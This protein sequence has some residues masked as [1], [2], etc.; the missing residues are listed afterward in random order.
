MNS[1]ENK[2]F[3]REL[4]GVLTGFRQVTDLLD[5]REKWSLAIATVLMLIAGFL[6]NLPAV[7]LGRFV[8]EII[9]LEDATFGLA[10]P[11]L[12]WIVL[13]ILLKEI[14][15]ILRKYLIEN[16]ATQSDKKQTVFVIDHLL[17]TDIAKFVNRYRVGALHGRIFRSIQ[18]FIRLLKL[19]FLDFFPTFFTAIAALF[20]AFYQKPILASFMILVIP[21]GLF[22]VI[23]QISSQKGIRL[24]LLRGKEEIDGKVVEMMGGLET[25]RVANTSDYEV[26][27]IETIAEKLRKI[28]I[29]HHVSMAFYDAAKYLNE[30]FFYLLVVSMSIF[31]AVNGVITKGDILT[32]S[33]LFMSVLSPLR[34]VH[35]ILDQA[36]ESSLKVA[37]LVDLRNQPLDQSF[38]VKSNL[39]AEE[40]EAVLNVQ[41]MSFS[42]SDDDPILNRISLK[43]HKGEKIGIAGASGSGKS[44]LIK[45]LL[46]LVHDYQGE[47]SL[48]GKDLKCLTRDEI[49]DKIA[50]IPQRTYIFSG[51]VR[52]NILYGCSRNVSDQ[53]V[54][55]AAREANID[56]E[57]SDKL[58]GLCGNVAENGSNLSGGQ[59]QRLALARLILRSPDILIFDEAT[60]ALD[61]TNEATIQK[62][63]EEV[64]SDKTFI[65]IA[66]RLSTLKNSDRV[67]VF[68]Q[69]RIVQEGKFGELSENEGLFREFLERGIV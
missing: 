37:D 42:Y 50:Y 7:I 25:I 54:M 5:Q 41:E 47:I 3:F 31:F 40:L 34:E 32:Y 26:E 35:R 55:D 20:I 23:K 38:A 67:L 16:V 61:N 56:R 6:V 62:N 49:A 13:I 15:T 30:A 51:T 39:E 63:I 21:A 14:L 43:I 2:G 8:D 65:T 59:R 4:K 48:F 33:I 36:H 12:L 52:D 60:S 53:E 18:G 29:K 45:I 58:G 19:G 11:F 1:K 10:V 68:D 44:T 64:F 9:G 27:K 17:K 24:E 46:R 57:I 66:H 69:G 28:E 22:I